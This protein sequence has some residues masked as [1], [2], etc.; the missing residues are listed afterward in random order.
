MEDKLLMFSAIG[1]VSAFLIK[2]YFQIEIN[3]LNKAAKD[4][5]DW[6]SVKF[7]KKTGNEGDRFVV[8]HNAMVTI[9]YVFIV[10]FGIIIIG[11]NI[12]I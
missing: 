10:F 2:A 1:W 12:D 4:I 7:I 3:R 8:L 6:D 9:F 5:E 11:S